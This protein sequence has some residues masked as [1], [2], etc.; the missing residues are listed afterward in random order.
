MAVENNSKVGHRKAGS[1]AAAQEE[2]AADQRMR[3][4]GEAGGHMSILDFCKVY[5][6]DKDTIQV[7]KR[8][9]VGVNEGAYLFDAGGK[10][11]G[12]RPF[13]LIRA[14]REHDKAKLTKGVDKSKE[15]NSQAVRQ[16]IVAKAERSMLA[17]QKIKGM[18]LW[19]D[20]V[21]MIVGEFLGST[22]AAVRAWPRTLAPK[23]QRHLSDV[24]LA[25]ADKDPARRE[26]KREA[27]LMTLNMIDQ[28]EFEVFLNDVLDTQIHHLGREM[29]QAVPTI[30]EM[31]KNRRSIDA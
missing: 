1:A 24:L 14:L 31:S 11:I 27:I 9:G 21:V 6:I 10:C 23:I 7:R 2:A 29:S 15:Q 13:V 22:N 16:E 25:K 19:I 28:G 17:T 30:I 18:T 4:T 5:P 8:E 26:A 3:V 12:V 20:D